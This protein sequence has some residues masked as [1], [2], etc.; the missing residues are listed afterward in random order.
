M[1]KPTQKDIDYIKGNY[2][3]RPSQ[4]IA[5]IIGCSRSY[6]SKIGREV[7]NGRK[8]RNRYYC[9]ENYFDGI[10]TYEQAYWL[11]F[12]MA[13]G[14]IYKRK[15][16]ENCQK[17]LR[18]S[19]AEKDTLH[20]EKFKKAIS[21]NHKIGRITRKKDGRTYSSLTIVSDKMTNSLAR[22]G[23]V[24][25]KTGNIE[26]PNFD[27]DDL[28]W[29]FIHGYID[30]DGSISISKDKNVYRYKLSVVGDKG[31]LLNMQHFIRQQGAEGILRKDNREY[32]FD[33]YELYFEKMEFLN[34]IFNNTYNREIIYLDRKLERVKK[35]YSE[36]YDK[37]K[38]FYNTPS[39]IEIS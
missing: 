23:C 22:L 9:N 24:E 17:W 14:C 18:I 36:K 11:G 13:D 7:S 10:D 8:R 29:G 4:E 26:F 21:S 15:N 34:L 16:N 38:E 20:L 2:M 12:I 3:R 33:F 35:Y 27:R 1:F 30:G 19:L 39:R 28:N 6:V 5:N 25:R 32:S 31:L 37:N